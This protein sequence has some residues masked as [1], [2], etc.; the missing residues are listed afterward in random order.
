MDDNFTKAEAQEK[1]GT[2]INVEVI[3]PDFNTPRISKKEQEKIDEW[4]N[5]FKK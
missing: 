4:L 5:S 2:T 1:D 3:E